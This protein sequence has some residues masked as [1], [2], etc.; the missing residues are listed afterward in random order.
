[1]MPKRKKK[2]PPAQ[3]PT[4]NFCTSD[5]HIMGTK[6]ECAVRSVGSIDEELFA[7]RV[8]GQII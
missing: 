2:I 1:M 6:R 7:A 4:P 5:N 8:G 3:N